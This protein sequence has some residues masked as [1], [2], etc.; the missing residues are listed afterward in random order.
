VLSHWIK[1]GGLLALVAI[2]GAVVL[3]S[4]HW[5]FTQDTIVSAL[6]EKF[7][8]AIEL[9]MFHG[10]YLTPGCVVE[11]VTFRRNSDRNARPIASI[12]RLTIQGSYWGLFS[13]PRRVRRVKVEGLRIFVSPGSERTVSEASPTGS[14]EKFALIIDEI[15]ADG[16][17]VEIAF[18]EPGTE[19][20]KFEIHRLAL[21]SVADDRPMSFHAALLNPK[22]PGEIRADGQFGPLRPRNVGQTLLSGS[23]LFQRADLGIFPGIRGTLSSI[24]KLNG[25]LEHI[26]IEGSTDSPDFQVK[27]SEHTVHLKTQFHAIVN[28]MDGDVALQSVHAQFER[29]SVVSQGEVAKKASSESKTVSLGATEQQ[30]RIQDWLRL[31]SKADRP[32]MTGAMNFRVQILVLPGKQDFIKRVNLG[33]D[34]GIDAASFRR[35]TTQE[36]V[37]N[38]SQLAKGEKVNDDPASVVENLKGHVELEDAIA[39]FSDLS[40]SLPGALARVHGTYGL[41]T[42]QVNLHGTLQVDSKLSKGSKGVKS[43]LLKSVEPFLKKKNAG[44]IVPIKIGG[45][46]S[47]PSYGLDVVP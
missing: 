4:S 40:F 31:L 10:T 3:V 14:L 47:H 25:V 2:G 22:P 1:I 38:L 43:V 32:A 20:L 35:S 27:R 8:T 36:K 17:L 18:G 19:P 45:T 42:E 13:T 6:Q 33:G 26:E 29:T 41:L 23:Y 28:G 9:N 16:A 11:G 7:S 46:F 21:N 5:P 24:G 12:E 15:I 44:E 34:F 39:T 30:G 37:D